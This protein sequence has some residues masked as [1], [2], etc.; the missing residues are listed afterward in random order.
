M[1]DVIRSGSKPV[2]AIC[3]AANETS[4]VSNAWIPLTTVSNFASTADFTF[5]TGAYTVKST[6]LYRI[7]AGGSVVDDGSATLCYV[8]WSDGTN[9]YLSGAGWGNNG[10]GVLAAPTGMTVFLTANDT[11]EPVYFTDSTAATEVNFT[12]FSITRGI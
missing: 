6:G 10:A 5:A 11:L 12:Q 9:T 2:Y 1:A 7:N 4:V 8:G 3:E